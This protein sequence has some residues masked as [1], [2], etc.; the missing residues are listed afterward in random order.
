[1]SNFSD[2]VALITGA[3]R[4]IGK[5]IALRFAQEGLD[6]ILAAR[7]VQDLQTVQRD[8]EGMGRRCQSIPTDLRNPESIK[9]LVQHSLEIMGQ[10]DI[11]VN[12]AG[13]GFWGPVDELTLDQYDEMFDVNM[14]AVFLLARAVI[15]H[16]KSKSHGHIIN[17]ASTSSRWTYPEGT[18]YCASKFAVLGLTKLWPKN[19]ARAVFELQRSV[20]DR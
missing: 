2:K 9:K 6:L 15:P 5:A 8:V 11:L 16:M 19:Y 7:N 17:I 20:P 3:S 13:V 4:G 14:R 18:L 10:I 12:N 1:M